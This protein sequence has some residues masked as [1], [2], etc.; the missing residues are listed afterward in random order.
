MPLVELV[1][2]DVVLL[3]LE[4]ADGESRAQARQ[5]RSLLDATR[6]LVLEHGLSAQRLNR[7]G[8]TAWVGAT[9]SPIELVAA[10]RAT[11]EG[12]S[13]YGNPTSISERDS[14][15]ARQPT[16]REREV[17]TLVEQ[18]LATRAIADR[19][20]TTP[21]TV[22]FHIGNLYTKLGASSRTE[23]VYLAR[24]RGWPDS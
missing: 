5:L 12:R 3:A 6:V 9:S 4:P 16:P 7:L 24:Q 14:D 19:L 15:V 1:R 21:R 23:M 18:G 22:H 8:V 11:A 10:V 20:Q 13:V 17:L 2:P